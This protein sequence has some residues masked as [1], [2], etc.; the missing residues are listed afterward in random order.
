[1]GSIWGNALKISIFGESHGGGIGVVLDG[2]PS[3]IL[4]MRILSCV[5]WTAGRRGKTNS[6]RHEKKLI[7]RKFYR[8]SIRAIPQA[9]RFAR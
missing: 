2:F 6:P 4:L 9:H 3:G 1:M 5:K 8:V 7:F